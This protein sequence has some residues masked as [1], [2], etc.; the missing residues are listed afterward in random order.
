KGR[1]P[2]KDLRVRRAVYQ[3]IDIDAIV[4]KVLRGQATATGSHFSRLVD[5]SVAELDRRLPYDPKAARV[6]LKEAG[7]P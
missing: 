4:S 1:N 6:L 5:G 2:F 7:Y 3:A